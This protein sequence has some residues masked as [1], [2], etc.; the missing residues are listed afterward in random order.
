[1]RALA[2]ALAQLVLQG[3]LRRGPRRSP[4]FNAASHPIEV[5]DPAAGNPLTTF[6][7]DLY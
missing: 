1:M 6:T 7:G 5:T 2:A 3:A 4:P